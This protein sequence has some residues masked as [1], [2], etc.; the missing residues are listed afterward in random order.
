MKVSRATA[1]TR[2][3]VVDA[4]VAA[5]WYLTEIGTESALNLMDGSNR[6]FAPE[7]I[8]SSFGRS[9]PAGWALTITNCKSASRTKSGI[10]PTCAAFSTDWFCGTTRASVEVRIYRVRLLNPS[11]A[12]FTHS[13]W[14]QGERDMRGSPLYKDQWSSTPLIP[15]LLCD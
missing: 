5:K 2:V 7:L 3:I 9:H 6:Q 10:F 15:D 13:R 12:L 14:C 1:P 11:Q 8:G 4:N